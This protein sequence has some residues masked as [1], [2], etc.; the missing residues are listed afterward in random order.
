VVNERGL[1]VRYANRKKR[2]VVTVTSKMLELL[3]LVKIDHSS[4]VSREEGMCVMEAVAYITGDEHSDTPKCV[5]PNVTDV[6]INLN[7]SMDEDDRQKLKDVVPRII[8]TYWNG[9]GGIF[10]EEKAYNEAFAEKWAEIEDQEVVD[11]DTADSA[12]PALHDAL[13]YAEQKRDAKIAELKARGTY[14]E[15]PKIETVVGVNG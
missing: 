13:D 15:P 9:E 10:P 6:M 4:H 11:Y 7:D 14:V 12:L 5:A 2:R 1:P 8:G 3:K